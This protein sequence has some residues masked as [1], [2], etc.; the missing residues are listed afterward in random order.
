M[1]FSRKTVLYTKIINVLSALW[2]MLCLFIYETIV[3]EMVVFV[4]HA[5]I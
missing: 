5:F 4:V 1:S 3:T 2:T